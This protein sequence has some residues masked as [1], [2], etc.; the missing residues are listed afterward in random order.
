MKVGLI[1]AMEE[2]LIELRD[3]LQEM[4]EVHYHQFV[5][6]T[7]KLYEHEVAIM[8]CGIGKVNAAVGT[9]LLI[10]KFHPECVINTGVAGGFYNTMNVGDIVVSTDVKHHDVD[11][12]IFD[13]EHGQIPRMPVSYD[14]NFT[15]IKL[16]GEHLPDNFTPQ[17]IKGTILSGDSFIHLEEQVKE[18]KEKFPF[19]MAVEMEGSAIGQT[20]YLFNIPFVVIRSISDIVTAEGSHMDY[21]QFVHMAAKNSAILVKTML[22]YLETVEK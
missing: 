12:T 18:I 3:S 22:K 16:A 17:I 19:I 21:Q 13:Y 14:A 9:T 1:A 4:Q 20:C 11:A 7:G 6:Y 2:E 8:L 10:D 5:Y 15:L